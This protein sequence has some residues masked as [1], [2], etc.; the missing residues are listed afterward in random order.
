MII[1]QR[2][3]FETVIVTPKEQQRKIKGVVCNLLVNY[4]QTC[5]VLPCPPERFGTYLLNFK[6]KL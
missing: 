5:N 2:I 1:V 4:A 6:R 3:V